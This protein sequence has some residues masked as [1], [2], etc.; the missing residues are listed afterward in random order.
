MKENG[1]I[2]RKNFIC[3]YLQTFTNFFSQ[4]VDDIFLLWDGGETQFF[5]FAARLNYRQPKI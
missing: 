2:L 1:N 4:F 3:P 5:D